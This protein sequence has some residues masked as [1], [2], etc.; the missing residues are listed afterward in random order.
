MAM[1]VNLS[2]HSTQ[3]DFPRLRM[4]VSGQETP[5]RV[6]TD[7]LAL[8][9]ATAKWVPLEV[10]ATKWGGGVEEEGG[11]VVLEV[12]GTLTP[13]NEEEDIIAEVKTPRRGEVIKIEEVSEEETSQK[14]MRIQENM[15]RR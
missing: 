13:D 2:L 15:R 12:G 1:R 9:G 6:Q 3:F 10:V 4:R 5:V 11:G 8:P 7:N 14:T